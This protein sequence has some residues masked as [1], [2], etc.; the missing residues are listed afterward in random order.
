MLGALETLGQ[1]EVDLEHELL[2]RDPKPKK[3]RAWV[4]YSGHAMRVNVYVLAWTTQAV[5]VRGI[6]GDGQRQE[7]WVWS[8]AVQDLPWVQLD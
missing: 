2:T 6:N 1:V 8:P 7:A 3:A 4:R 5:R